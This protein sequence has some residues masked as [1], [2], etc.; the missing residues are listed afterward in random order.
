MK[1]NLTNKTRKIHPFNLNF[2]W[3]PFFHF[4]KAMVRY[5]LEKKT[6]CFFLGGKFSSK[7]GP[8]DQNTRIPKARNPNG[9]EP[10]LRHAVW[11]SRRIISCESSWQRCRWSFWREKNDEISPPKW[12]RHFLEAGH[13]IEKKT[14]P[15]G[16]QL[17]MHMPS[18][19]KC[20]MVVALDIETL[21]ET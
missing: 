10:S 9:W 20:K 17:V 16:R 18:T 3:L 4:G 6:T 19:W 11:Q 21:Q 5:T 2:Y 12:R 8:E 14:R 1:L 7:T 13:K 15:D